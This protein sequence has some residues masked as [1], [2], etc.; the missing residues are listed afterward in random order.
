MVMDDVSN[1]PITWLCAYE[2]LKQAGC[3]CLYVSVYEK[4]TCNGGHVSKL[5]HPCP[6][7]L[8]LPAQ[9]SVVRDHVEVVPG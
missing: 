6:G 9:S 3:L 7:G 2:S 1:N 8:L 5:S 4:A